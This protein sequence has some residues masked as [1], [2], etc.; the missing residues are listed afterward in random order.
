MAGKTLILVEG[1]DNGL[2]YVQAARHLN[3]HPIM[4]ASDPCEYR[5]LEKEKIDAIRVDTG[6]IDALIQECSS[7]GVT[8]DIAGI[9]SSSEPLYATVGELCQHFELPGPN[10]EAV[11]R[12]C[13]KFIQR[14]ILTKAGVPTPAYRLAANAADVASAAAEIG[15]PVIVKPATGSGGSKGVR[16]CQNAN[17]LAEHT[18]RLLNG[19]HKWR[20][21]PRIL[22]EEFAE[23]TYYIADTLGREVFQIATAEF[24]PP[25]HFII[26]E[27]IYPAVLTYDE[28]KLI[29]DISQNCLQALGLGWGPTCI[30]FRW[31][32]LGPV[33]IEVNPRLAG[34][35][36]PQLMQL[37]YGV[38]LIAEHI[39]LVTGDSCDLRKRHSHTVAS[40]FLIPDRDGILDWIGGESQA[41]AVPGVVE[42]KLYVEPKTRFFRNGDYRDR[43]GHV[44][45]TSS[46]RAQTQ[47][48]LKHATGLINWSIS[49]SATFDNDG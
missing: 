24:G 45:A 44:I 25:P 42:V 13:D 16:L 40:R 4:L 3:I 33:V 10:S 35:V 28:H 48:I 41:A 7:L 32:K 34:G 30:E 17:E 11:E 2:Q 26:S 27:A 22:V 18:T 38:D 36:G 46:S 1:K 8:Y 21:S 49:P 20:S 23:G 9:T 5:Y 37:A 31:T 39:K 43:I 15:L 29:T 19:E 12:C 6:N 14:Q 47:T